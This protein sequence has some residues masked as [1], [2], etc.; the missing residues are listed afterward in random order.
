[1]LV[2]FI[3]NQL[4]PMHKALLVYVQSIIIQDTDQSNSKAA[5]QLTSVLNVNKPNINECTELFVHI[6][7]CENSAFYS[8]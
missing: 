2:F 6:K 1:M 3:R 4:K 7:A 5:A 8:L